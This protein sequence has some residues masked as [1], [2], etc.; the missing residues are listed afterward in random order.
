MKWGRMHMSDATD[1]NRRDFK[2][3][4][5]TLR[6]RYSDLAGPEHLIRSPVAALPPMSA[7]SKRLL[8]RL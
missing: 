8:R 6:A 3:I 5:R 2:L 7:K 1:M 4:I